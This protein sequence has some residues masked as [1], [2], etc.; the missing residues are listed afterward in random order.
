MENSKK[1][2]RVKVFLCI[3]STVQRREVQLGPSKRVVDPAFDVFHQVLP[4]KHDDD[5]V[6][7]ALGYLQHTST[8]GYYFQFPELTMHSLTFWPLYNVVIAAWNIS[9]LSFSD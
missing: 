5:D 7:I 9:P 2:W 3:S 8:H 1:N 6:D 4:Y